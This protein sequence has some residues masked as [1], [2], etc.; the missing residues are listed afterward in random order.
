M[1][2]TAVLSSPSYCLQAMNPP[3]LL[4]ASLPCNFKYNYPAPYSSSPPKPT[5][6]SDTN[7]STG[8]PPLCI[9]SAT[10][11]LSRSYHFAFSIWLPRIPM[12]I[13]EIGFAC[14]EWFLNGLFRTFPGHA[15]PFP[16]P[17]WITNFKVY[18]L[19]ALIQVPHIQIPFSWV[20]S[21]I[22]HSSLFQKPRSLSSLWVQPLSTWYAV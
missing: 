16:I 11:F 3:L 12:F 13:C 2:H 10:D 19:S 6:G 17:S 7:F 8:F 18:A 22:W 4:L 5:A 21:L 15:E 20:I 9:F 14:G 1:I